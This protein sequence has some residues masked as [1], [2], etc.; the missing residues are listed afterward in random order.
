MKKWKEIINFVKFT[1]E[2]ASVI[3]ASKEKPLNTDRYVKLLPRKH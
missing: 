3:K 2:N 1:G